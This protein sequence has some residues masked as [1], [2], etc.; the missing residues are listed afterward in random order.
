MET[1]QTESVFLP[2]KLPCVQ[3]FFLKRS[4]RFTVEIRLASGQ[5]LLLHSNNTGAMLGLQRPGSLIL[6]SKSQNLKRKLHYTQ[7]A[8]YVEEQKGLGQAS[9]GF[10]VGVNTSVPNQL[11][12][13][14]FYARSIPLLAPYTTM[15]SEVKYGAS[16]LDAHFSGA[17]CPELWVECKNVT[18]VEDGVAAFPDAKSE[19]AR[20][21]LHELTKLVK[22]GQ[23]AAMFYLVQRPDAHCFAPADYIDE[24]YARLLYLASKSGVVIL[25][26]Q[27]LVS[28]K[29]IALGPRLPLAKS[30]LQSF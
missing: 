14:A 10:W 7:E 27:A 2:F 3:G 1:N 17:A 18:L 23:K 30:F 15:R 9:Q 6:A 24:E 12:A 19:R 21:H 28:P 11:L 29:G 26:Y 4:K 22:C 13:K 16:R 8:V 20:K 5:N 25:A